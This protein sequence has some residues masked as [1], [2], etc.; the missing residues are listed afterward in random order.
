MARL[1]FNLNNNSNFSPSYVTNWQEG[2]LAG[3][4]PT[5]ERSFPIGT[6]D[7]QNKWIGNGSS[8]LEGGFVNPDI[9]SFQDPRN[10]GDN[11]YMVFE[12]SNE[13]KYS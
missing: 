12:K 11:D 4:M 7:S 2:G 8:V 13:S 5:K 3:M 1:S 6:R 9:D 10:K